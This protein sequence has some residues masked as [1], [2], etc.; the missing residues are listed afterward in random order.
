[1]S[2]HRRRESTELNEYQETQ[3][4]EQAVQNAH[5]FFQENDLAI[6]SVISPFLSPNGQKLI[7]FF[8]NF[9]KENPNPQALDITGLLMQTLKNTDQNFLQN[10]LPLFKNLAGNSNAGE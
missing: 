10:L 3:S 1:M 2:H 6:L 8:V 4:K 9:G 7:S 5:L